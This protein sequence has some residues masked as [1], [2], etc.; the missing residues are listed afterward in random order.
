[1]W[2]RFPRYTYLLLSHKREHVRVNK[3][4]YELDVMSTSRCSSMEF[5]CEQKWLA[6]GLGGT[7]N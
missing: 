7:S 2:S 1:M 4:E 3:C 5:F 6:V